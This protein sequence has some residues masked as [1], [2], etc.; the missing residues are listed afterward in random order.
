MLRNFT[1]HHK[2]TISAAVLC[3][4]ADLI[5]TPLTHAMCVCSKSDEVSGVSLCLFSF[6]VS[7]VTSTALPC[8]GSSST[9]LAVKHSRA[10][11]QHS[12][13]TPQYTGGAVRYREAPRTPNATRQHPTSQLC[14]SV[15]ITVIMYIAVAAATTQKQTSIVQQRIVFCA[16]PVTQVLERRRPALS[17]LQVCFLFLKKTNKTKPVPCLKE[18][19]S[20]SYFHCDI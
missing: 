2:N 16:S 3:L 18:E 1:L 4:H 12:K 11:L 14:F 19:Q 6:K 9:L 10:R 15:H 20:R 8:S 5:M 17:D 13:A 7:P